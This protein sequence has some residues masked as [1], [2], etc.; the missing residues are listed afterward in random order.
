MD[1]NKIRYF[2]V[3]AEN[4]SYTR[5]SEQLFISQS[6]LSRHIRSAEEEFGI[7]LFTR[8]TR[9]VSLTAAGAVMAKGLG[10][11]SEQYR[12]LLE[13]AN[14]AQSG[15]TGEIRL[16]VAASCSLGSVSDII[17]DYCVKHPDLHINLS[18]APT[19][20]RLLNDTFGGRYDIGLG[21]ERMPPDY[22]KLS[23]LKLSKHPLCIAVSGRHPLAD[24]A[25]RAISLK[26]LKDETIFLPLDEESTTYN[27]L[28]AACLAAGFVMNTQTVSDSMSA[29]LR[30]EANRGVTLIY[31]IAAYRGNSNLVFRRIGDLDLDGWFTAYWNSDNRNP[32]VLSFLD[33][34]RASNA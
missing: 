15:F 17:T 28:R 21:I 24:H 25:E 6:M 20:E 10:Q 29:K 2:L 11:L 31:D 9:E 3:L 22:R 26:D 34:I 19:L 13:Q 23:S 16:G 7:T 5:A 14:Y 33:Y 30:T 32:A 1:F 12:D 27:E 4:L 18:A 8:N